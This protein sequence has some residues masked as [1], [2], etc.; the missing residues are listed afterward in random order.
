MWKMADQ[1]VYNRNRNNL[2]TLETKKSF[3]LLDNPGVPK[4]PI[5]LAPLDYAKQLSKVMNVQEKRHR[6]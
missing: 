6:S 3:S 5:K 2:S 4:D 1:A